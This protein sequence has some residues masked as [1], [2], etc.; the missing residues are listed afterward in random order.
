MPEKYPGISGSGTRVLWLDLWEGRGEGRRR[1]ERERQ[2][3]SRIF[4][5]KSNPEKIRDHAISGL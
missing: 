2:E 4:E 5:K 1:R 3:H